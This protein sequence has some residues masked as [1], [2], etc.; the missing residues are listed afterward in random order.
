M[1]ESGPDPQVYR[2]L[3]RRREAELTGVAESGDEAGRTVELDQARVGRLSRMDALQAQAMAKESGRRRVAELKR[4]A[5]ALQRIDDD[6][7]GYCLTCGE[8][9]D[10]RRLRVDP[11]AT[12]CLGCAEKAES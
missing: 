11:A 4:I 6:E 7:Y 2:E 12:L 10:E 5:A 8:L 1:S 3:L 9:I